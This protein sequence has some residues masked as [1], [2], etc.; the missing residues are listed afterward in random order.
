MTEAVFWLSAILAVYP[1]LIYPVV[2]RAVALI[3]NGQGSTEGVDTP[4]VTVLIAAYNE[5]ESIECT[6]RNKLQQD[7]PE[8]RLDVVVVSDGSD[9]GTDDIVARLAQESKRLRWLRQ[10]PRAGKASALNLAM[11]DIRSGIVVFADANSIYDADAIRQLVRQFADPTVGYITGR[12]IYVD[13]NDTESRDRSGAFIRYENMLRSIET[14]I[15]S[16]VG[17]NGGIDA[18]R[19]ELYR[20]MSADDLPDFVLPL[21]LIADGYFVKYERRAVLR[22]SVLAS[23]ADEFKMRARVALRGLWALYKCRR[24]FNPFKYRFFS[25]KLISHKLLR[26]LGFLPMLAAALSNWLLVDKSSI[27]VAAASAQVTFAACVALGFL[28]PYLAERVSLVRHSHYF[29]LVN[30]AFAIAFTRFVCGQ[31]QIMWKPRTG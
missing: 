6:V 25:F 21:D 5:A 11:R 7:Y 10:E 14:R 2:I 9:D 17:V 24:L 15:G 18:V 20:P 13:E 16:I 12:M 30:A 29:F 26:Y 3:A 22:E 28:A 4:H 27:Y 23:S 8:D 19:R 31:K 1:Y